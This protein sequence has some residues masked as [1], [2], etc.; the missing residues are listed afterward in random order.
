MTP[1]L[2]P[3]ILDLSL[4]GAGLSGVV[5]HSASRSACD[6]VLLARCTGTSTSMMLSGLPRSECARLLSFCLNALFSQSWIALLRWCHR[7]HAH[8]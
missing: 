2:V 1:W 6:P 4:F 5:V 7:G 8:R 3:H